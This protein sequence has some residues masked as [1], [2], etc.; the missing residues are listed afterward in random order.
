M[1]GHPVPVP[2]S[3]ACHSSAVG[4]R[5]KMRIQKA[6]ASFRIFIR[7]F[8]LFDGICLFDFDELMEIRPWVDGNSPPLFDV[9]ARG[10]ALSVGEDSV[11]RR[12][13]AGGGFE[14][15]AR[16]E[17]HVSHHLLTGAAVGSCEG[18]V[19]AE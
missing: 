5:P 13:A 7:P 6:R 10:R 12:V 1:G 17:N 2:F 15:V 9:T 19:L 14:V 4:P 16:K 18:A 11:D 3:A 8:Y